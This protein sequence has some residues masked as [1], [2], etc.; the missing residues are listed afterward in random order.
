MRGGHSLMGTTH[1]LRAGTAATRGVR[2]RVNEKVAAAKPCRSRQYSFGGLSTLDLASRNVDLAP[3][4]L[5]SSSR[6][7]F[8][9]A[10]VVTF[11]APPEELEDGYFE[12]PTPL[13]L[14][15]GESQ[16]AAW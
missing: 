1:L 2:R 4:A 9:S 5:G 8:A 15:A 10:S 11:T 14:V 12:R 7:G 16:P 13:L 6:R 3:L